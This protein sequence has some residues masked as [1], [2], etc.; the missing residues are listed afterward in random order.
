MLDNVIGD[1]ERGDVVVCEYD[2]NHKEM[3]VV[4]P[5][6][7]INNMLFVKCEYYDEGKRVEKEFF[8]EQL[9]FVKKLDVEKYPR[10]VLLKQMLDE[11][12]DLGS[13]DIVLTYYPNKDNYTQSV[14]FETAT[15]PEKDHNVMISTMSKGYCGLGMHI[16][17]LKVYD[18]EDG[19]ITG[20]VNFL[21]EKFF[22]G[23]TVRLQKLGNDTYSFEYLE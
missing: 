16:H 7:E 23:K 18:G 6:L 14:C 1:I 9:S 17:W 22:D 10:L 21:G 4:N 8:P 11:V 20:I 13:E 15:F 2:S 12:F 3:V 5:R 19:K